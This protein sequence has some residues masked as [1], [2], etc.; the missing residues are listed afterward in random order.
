MAGWIYILTYRPQG[1]LYVGVTR[2]LPQ[3]LRDCRAGRSARFC[4]TYDCTRLV[5]AERHPSI[6]AAIAR[7]LTL[8]SW[9]RPWKLRLIDDANPDWAD[10]AE[11]ILADGRAFAPEAVASVG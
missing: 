8:R 6:C 1:L 2:D 4:K 10:L 11:A 9:C 5:W 7:E 3:R